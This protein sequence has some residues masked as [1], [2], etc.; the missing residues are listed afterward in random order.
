[1]EVVS[2]RSAAFC[3]LDVI[4]ESVRVMELAYWWFWT[5]DPKA[6]IVIEEFFNKHDSN[7][8]ANNWNA[9]CYGDTRIS[10]PPWSAVTCHRFVTPRRARFRAPCGIALNP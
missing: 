3:P 10:E 8:R 4:L 2:D 9:L 7:D 1:M 6:Q 5:I